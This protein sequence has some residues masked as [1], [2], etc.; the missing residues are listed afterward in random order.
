MVM[1]V[2]F[3]VRLPRLKLYIK[4]EQEIHFKGREMQLGAY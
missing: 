2:D 4:P 3:G 1:T